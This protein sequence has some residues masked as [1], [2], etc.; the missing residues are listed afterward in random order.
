MGAQPSRVGRI[1]VGARSGIRRPHPPAFEIL[2][3]VAERGI[4]VGGRPSGTS[5]PHHANSRPVEPAA[6]RGFPIGLGR[7]AL[8]RPCEGSPLPAL[9][10]CPFGMPAATLVF[11]RSPLLVLPAGVAVG[12]ADKEVMPRDQTFCPVRAIQGMPHHD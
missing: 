7:P 12:S 8:F 1:V 11:S 3:H 6:R 10:V 4:T 2:L 9:A 5:L